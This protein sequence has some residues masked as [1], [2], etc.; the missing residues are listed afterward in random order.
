MLFISK[1]TELFTERGAAIAVGHSTCASF[2]CLMLTLKQCFASNTRERCSRREALRPSDLLVGQCSPFYRFHLRA[3][4]EVAVTISRLRG[5]SNFS[6][7]STAVWCGCK[8]RNGPL[9]GTDEVHDSESSGSGTPGSVESAPHIM[10]LTVL[11]LP[12]LPCL[13]TAESPHPDTTLPQ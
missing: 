8:V 1:F 3:E 4:C 7:L 12:C 11:N 10:Y 13:P 5:T 6:L 9:P 2:G